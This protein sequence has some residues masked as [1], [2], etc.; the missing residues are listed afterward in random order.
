MVTTFYSFVLAGNLKKIQPRHPMLVMPEQDKYIPN[1]NIRPGNVSYVIT[2]DKPKQLQQFEFGLKGLRTVRPFL[3]SEG[4]RNP[5][6]DLNYNG[7]K[8]IFLQLGLKQLI[9]NRRCLVLADA[10]ITGKPETP[11][12]VY[13]RNKQRPFC[14]AGIWNKTIAEE[15]GEDVFSFGIITVTANELI[16]GLGIKRMPVIVHPQDEGKWLNPAA[17]LSKIIGLLEVCPTKLMNAYPVSPL[18]T[19]SENSI[20]LIQPKGDPVINESTDPRLPQKKREKKFTTP[21]QLSERI[22]DS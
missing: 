16:A 20:S 21:I 1:F 8:A 3:R 6:D 14:F 18:E 12:L 9:H 15:T 19:K 2:T 5:Y 7:A 13:L 17:N 22:K 11:Y 4:T 10:F